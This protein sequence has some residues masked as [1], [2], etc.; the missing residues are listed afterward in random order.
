MEKGNYCPFSFNGKCTL[1]P[2][3]YNDGLCIGGEQCKYRQSVNR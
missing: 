1:Y 3:E 2:N